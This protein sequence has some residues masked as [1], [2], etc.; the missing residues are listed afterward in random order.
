MKKS[1][2]FIGRCV[3]TNQGGYSHWGGMAIAGQGLVF[4]K[5]DRFKELFALLDPKTPVLEITPS[6]ISMRRKIR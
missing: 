4:L 1:E 3:K 2:H 6:T 5:I